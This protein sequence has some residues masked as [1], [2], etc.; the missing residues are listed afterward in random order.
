MLST[1]LLAAIAS[2]AAIGPCEDTHTDC[3]GWA[4]IGECEA[5][6][7]WMERN[8]PVSC[9]TCPIAP[10][11]HP[12]ASRNPIPAWARG[13]TSFRLYNLGRAFVRGG[14]PGKARA[15][16][17]AS[18]LQG[19][20]VSKEACDRLQCDGAIDD[21]VQTMELQVNPSDGRPDALVRIPGAGGL[22]EFDFRYRPIRAIGPPVDAAAYFKSANVLLL[23][24]ARDQL[25]FLLR[26]PTAAAD[27]EAAFDAAGDAPGAFD[28][29]RAYLREQLAG[30]EALLAAGPDARG[31]GKTVEHVDPRRNAA[32]SSMRRA[33]WVHPA[34]RVPAGALNPGIDFAALETRFLDGTPQ[35]LVI[36]DFLSPAAL[37]SVRKFALY[38][39]IWYDPKSHP[40]VGASEGYLGAYT[41]HGFN[42]DVIL[43]IEEEIRAAFP[44][45]IGD[46]PLR[47]LWG[48]KYSE[49]SGEGIGR[50]AD[51]SALNLNLWLTPDSANLDP[52]GGG[53]LKIWTSTAPLDWKFQEYN[54]YE[55]MDRVEG[56]LKDSEVMDVAYKQNRLILFNGNYFHKTAK[57]HFKK[58]Y[59]NRRLNLTLL[60]GMRG[61]TPSTDDAHN[62]KFHEARA[63]RERECNRCHAK[64]RAWCYDGGDGHGGDSDSTECPG[65]CVS[66]TVGA[67]AC[68]QIAHTVSLDSTEH[69]TAIQ[70]LVAT[71]LIQ[72]GC[73][74]D[75]AMAYEKFYVEA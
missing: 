22:T 55:G 74:N 70:K 23:E 52:S 66:N 28:A 69:D 64:G 38:S 34:P 49:G 6:P 32:V 73:N 15:A 65:A 60:F 9:A 63:R 3:A 41:S 57:Y 21:D 58:G 16:F 35:V 20:G 43:Q 48:Y 19:R 68:G 71:S 54:S 13:M 67:C 72:V 8:C 33:T 62:D 17:D 40:G 42:P 37:V 14:M 56:F 75:Y 46:R 18:L 36:D 1:L 5:N 25:A 24:H 7:T 27:M 51:E 45:I 59:T 26:D 12:R 4:E 39:T 44:R 30:Y 11:A 29:M 61:R 2:C 10:L 47:N 50:H 31:T 53:G